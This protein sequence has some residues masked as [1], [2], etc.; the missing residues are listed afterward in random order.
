MAE[1]EVASVNKLE[2]VRPKKPT[3][4]EVK[5]EIQEAAIGIQLLLQGG[6]DTDAQLHSAEDFLLLKSEYAEVAS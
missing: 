2:A 3:Y 1:E 4:K 5:E 6:G